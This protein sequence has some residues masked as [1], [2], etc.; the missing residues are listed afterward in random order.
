MRKLIKPQA[1]LFDR[2]VNLVFPGLWSTCLVTKHNH[3]ALKCRLENL[4]QVGELYYKV[5]MVT[6]A[7]G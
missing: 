7:A 4:S 2:Q 1:D 3:K 6:L 5:V